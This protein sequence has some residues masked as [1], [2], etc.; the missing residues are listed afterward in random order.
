MVVPGMLDSQVRELGITFSDN[1]TIRA[2]GDRTEFECDGNM[3]SIV[4]H[5]L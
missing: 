2:I 5:E 3:E 1:R 4:E